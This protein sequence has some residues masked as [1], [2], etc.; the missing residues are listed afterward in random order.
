MSQIIIFQP[1]SKDAHWLM[2]LTINNQRNRVMSCLKK[3]ER[4]YK[5]AHQSNPLAIL[6]LHR[7]Y[8]AIRQEEGWFDKEIVKLTKLVQ[9]HVED[10]F[11][12]EP[13]QNDSYRIRVTNPVS[14]TFYKLINKMDTLMCLNETCFTLGIYEQRKLFFRKSESYKKAVMRIVTSISHYKTDQVN[15]A[16][17]KLSE[18]QKDYLAIAIYSDV[19]PL[20]SD[21]AFDRLKAMCE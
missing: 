1:K 6:Q 20:L 11:Y 21:Q 13:Y 12:Y 8:S 15:E 17:E 4:L 19:M 3:I 18:Q 9:K 10:K 16:I 14:A 5:E 7:W 2:N